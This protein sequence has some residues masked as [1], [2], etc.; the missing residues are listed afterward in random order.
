M[1]EQH[2]LAGC[3]ITV[4]DAV[5]GR[6]FDFSRL[7]HRLIHTYIHITCVGLDHEEV[8]KFRVDIRGTTP[9]TLTVVVKPLVS[10]VDDPCKTGLVPFG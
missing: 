10:V 1:R 9:A 4:T 3:G 7:G 8:Q 6:Y 2:H 5:I